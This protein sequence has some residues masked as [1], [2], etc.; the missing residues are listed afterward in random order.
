MDVRSQGQGGDIPKV[1]SGSFMDST[2]RHTRRPLPGP[3]PAG[4]RGE[5]PP[6]RA[7]PPGRGPP[8]W[9]WQ[10]QGR[11]PPPAPAR[12]PPAG[13]GPPGRE[14]PPRTAAKK[15]RRTPAAHTK[16]KRTRPIRAERGAFMVARTSFLGAR[17]GRPGWLS[18]GGSVG[19]G[20][21][22]DLQRG[23]RPTPGGSRLSP[24]RI[25]I[26]SATAEEKGPQ[27]GSNLVE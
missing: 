27:E 26:G 11:R 2:T 6:G 9:G 3:G 16:A 21:G 20:A 23:F 12:R 4:L 7:P 15:R 14:S 1:P 25:T 18:V 5:R 10:R 8:G 22:P 19:T 13:R 24:G 17:S